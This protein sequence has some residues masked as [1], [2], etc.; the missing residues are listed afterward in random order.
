MAGKGRPPTPTPILA[1]RG[2]RKAKTRKHE[3]TAL[4]LPTCPD[5]L[6]ESGKTMWTALAAQLGAMEVLGAVD[7]QA[8]GRY[9][10]LWG[11]WR[12]AEDH[13]VLEGSVVPIC[14]REGDVT[15]MGLSPYVKI[16]D[17]LAD[18]LLRLEQQF[19]M[20][21]SARA[22]LGILLDTQA[23]TT[24]KTPQEKDKARFFRAG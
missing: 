21:P 22:S 23:K 2:S 9:C 12:E 3:P 16:A 5:W 11:R 8:L 18:K 15:A 4:G 13:I 1:L 20:T 14:T 17:S 19:G 6:S 10:H 7:Q 24:H